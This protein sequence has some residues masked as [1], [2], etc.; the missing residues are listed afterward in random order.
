MDSIS[1]DKC[2]RNKRRRDKRR[3]DKMDIMDINDI[4]ED[5]VPNFLFMHLN[6]SDDGTCVKT[7]FREEARCRESYDY[8]LAYCIATD[9]TAA[10]KNEGERIDC[11]KSILKASELSTLA[12]VL[13]HAKGRRM[14]FS[15]FKKLF[16]VIDFRIPNDPGYDDREEYNELVRTASNLLIEELTPLIYAAILRN[17]KQRSNASK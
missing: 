8:K 4:P 15:E 2:C 13:F 7:L 3:R 17:Q 10:F 14:T 11:L 9:A 6:Y 1:T 12:M 5:E 16:T